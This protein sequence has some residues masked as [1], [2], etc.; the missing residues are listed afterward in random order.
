MARQTREGRRISDELL[1]ELLAG[2]DPA[3]FSP[4]KLLGF[5]RA[6]G[7]RPRGLRPSSTACLFSFKEHARARARETTG[8]E[9]RPML[10]DLPS[11]RIL[12]AHV[13]ES[14]SAM[15]GFTSSESPY[16]PRPSPY[17]PGTVTVFTRIY[18]QSCGSPGSPVRHSCYHPGYHK[19]DDI[20]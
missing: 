19:T 1:D 18:R 12:C 14:L 3:E 7:N 4:G 20:A 5:V 10:C 11:I 17:R 16:P 2:D 6:P 15:V 13:L 8:Q 9:P